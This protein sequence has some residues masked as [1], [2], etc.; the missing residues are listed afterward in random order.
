MAE[1]F[2]VIR[3]LPVIIE[4]IKSLGKFLREKFGDNPEKAILDAS[5][6]FSLLNSAKTPEEKQKAARSIADLIR[7]L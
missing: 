6:A 2:A 4:A 1:F 5:T 3:S 7:R